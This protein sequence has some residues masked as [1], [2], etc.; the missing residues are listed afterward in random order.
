MTVC[1]P[2][3][4]ANDHPYVEVPTILRHVSRLVFVEGNP[5]VVNCGCVSEC[6]FTHAA[7]SV[8]CSGFVEVKRPSALAAN[9]KHAVEGKYDRVQLAGT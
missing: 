8:K 1:L 7:S 9:R 4:T 2:P 3:R 6:Y 5:L